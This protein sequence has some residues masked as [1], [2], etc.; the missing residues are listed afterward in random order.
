MK[1]DLI[2]I[3]EDEEVISQFISLKLQ[4][5]GYKTIEANNGSKGLSLISS[6]CPD[7]ILL[8]LGLPDIDGIDVITEIRS[9]STVPIIVIS[10][11]HDNHYIIESL[12]KGAD[13]YITKP[14]DNDILMARI[15]T[16]LRRGHISKSIKSLNGGIYKSGDLVIDYDKR[17]VTIEGEIVKLTPIEY[18]I[19]V[20][21]SLN[22]GA[23]MTHEFLSKE[24][25]GP[26]INKNDAL[27]VNVANLR[28]KIE[29]NTSNPKYILTE[30]GVG[31][32][33]I[34]N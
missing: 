28:R 19:I 32:R 9:W 26:H 12:E 5:E 31:Y 23:V 14:F 16:A 6:H 3:I 2:M 30:M 11:R 15:K 27:R 8:D 21:L 22:A 4:I 25:W 10:A 24:I 20:L 18:K 1:K 17:L 7:L 29:K 33:M 13:D 34:E